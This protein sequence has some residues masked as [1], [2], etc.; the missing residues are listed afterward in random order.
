MPAACSC[1]TSTTR[2]PRTTQMETA[3]QD[4]PRQITTRTRSPRQ[5]TE[6]CK[7]STQLTSHTVH[8]HL[9]SSPPLPSPLPLPFAVLL[10][11]RIASRLAVPFCLLLPFAAL[12][13]S[14]STPLCLL[15]SASLVFSCPSLA[16]AAVVASRG[17]WCTLSSLALEGNQSHVRQTEKQIDLF[18]HDRSSDDDSIE[19]MARASSSSS[20][21]DR[22]QL[23]ANA[24]ERMRNA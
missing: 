14:S 10:P 3:T 11:S 18:E 19:G 1:S 12:Q 7:A 22:P 24:C 15:L 23:P 2:T 4:P 6:G 16:A 17:S 5:R 8:S 21:C 20:R 9:L 13:V